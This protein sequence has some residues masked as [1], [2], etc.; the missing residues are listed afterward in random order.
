MPV[1][2]NTVTKKGCQLLRH[3]RAGLGILG[4]QI[5]WMVVNVLTATLKHLLQ[6]IFPLGLRTRQKTT[7]KIQH[8][9]HLCREALEIFLKLDQHTKTS[10][11]RS[12]I[13]TVCYRDFEQRQ[14][15]QSIRLEDLV[16]NP[17]C[18]KY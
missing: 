16:L 18:E 2:I 7:H 4:D 8:L 10:L 1:S 9:R 17:L 14:I 12:Q 6:K 3:H 11:A 5:L 13:L 15:A